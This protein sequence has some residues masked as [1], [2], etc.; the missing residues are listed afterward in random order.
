MTDIAL[1]PAQEPATPKK[2]GPKPRISAKMKIALTK[3]IE[4]GLSWR[5]C[6]SVAGLSEQ[7]IYKAIATPHVKVF[8]KELEALVSNDIEIT[9][10]S[11]KLRAYQ[12]GRELLDQE[13]DKRIKAKMVELFTGEGRKG[14]QINVNQAVNVEANI[15]GGYEFVRPGQR[16]VDITPD[17]ASS[18]EDAEEP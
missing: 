14:Q 5:E 8:M 15:G 3:R 9:R 2:R 16:I 7:A 1:T 4:N 17:E 11:N 13:D 10:R 6:A 12:A 18:V